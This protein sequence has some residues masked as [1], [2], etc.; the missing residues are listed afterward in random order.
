ME[1]L[2]EDGESQMYHQ[3]MCSTT[4]FVIVPYDDNYQPMIATISIIIPHNY[5]THNVF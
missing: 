4:L 1:I 5:F 2:K 3:T